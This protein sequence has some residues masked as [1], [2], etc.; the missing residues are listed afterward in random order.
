M[1]RQAIAR[2]PSGYRVREVREKWRFYREPLGDGVELVMME[3]PGGEFWMGASDDEPE[4]LNTDRPRHR[5]TVGRFFLGQT[6]VT[7]SQWRIV[8]SQ[9]EQV[10]IELNPEPSSFK[11]DQRAVEQ[12]DGEEATEFCRRL[13][14]RTGRDYRLPSEAQWEYAC[15]AGTT[16]PFHYGDV[17]TDELA[18]YRATATYKGNSEGVYRGRTTDVGIFPPNRFGLYDMHGNVLEL[19]ED[20]WHSS[21]EGA[22]GNSDAWIEENRTATKRVLR[23]GH[24]G[25]TPGSCR[26]ATRIRGSH[27]FFRSYY[28]G[29]R[30]CCVPPREL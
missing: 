20:D 24:W 21:Y 9:F 25:R 27:S 1:D 26:S 13:S 16:T 23:G 12:V 10:G 6:V 11:G 7:Q 8:A 5:V 29:F 28:I 19:C 14:E 22:P 17:L 4:A 3:I 30:V 18:N 2:V 15:R